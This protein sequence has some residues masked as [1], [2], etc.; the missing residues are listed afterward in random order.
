[1][2]IPMFNIPMVI[3]QCSDWTTKKQKLLDFC[4]SDN[5]ISDGFV[6]T[7]Y[8]NRKSS[9]Y[10]D[11]G[12][13]LQEEIV[14]FIQTLDLPVDKVSLLN[15]WTQTALTGMSHPMHNHGAYGYSAICYLEFAKDEH[16]A[17]TFVAPYLNFLNGSLLKFTPE[18]EEGTVIFF[19][20]SIGH[21]TDPN[22]SD[23]PRKILSFNF[24]VDFD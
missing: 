11:L 3:L 22:K 2:V 9:F 7:D 14:T 1:M 16:T 18:V 13:I 10:A 24:K 23:K 17:A 6:L 5:L 4:V 12:S 19:P 8:A 21:Y 15:S 20:S